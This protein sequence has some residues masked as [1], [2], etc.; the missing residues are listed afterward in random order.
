MMLWKMYLLSNMAIWG[1]HVGF[2]GCT[3]SSKCFTIRSPF[4]N[5]LERRCGLPHNSGTTAAQRGHRDTRNVASFVDPFPKYMGVS[6]NRSYPKMDG[7]EW[8]S[9]LKWMIWG[10]HPYFWKHPY[11]PCCY[12]N[13]L[14]SLLTQTSQQGKNRKCWTDCKEEFTTL[15]KLELYRGMSE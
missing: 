5:F 15:Y 3:H 13:L 6:K 4:G 9:L 7:L 11:P 2:G 1:I 10:A 14:K 8:K 12:T